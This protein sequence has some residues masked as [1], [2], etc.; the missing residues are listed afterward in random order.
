MKQTI[1]QLMRTKR[2]CL[3]IAM[4]SA[5][6]AL[7]SYAQQW[8]RTQQG[9]RVDLNKT[10]VNICY[11]NNATVRV[12]KTP[13]GKTLTRK[14]LVVTE[15]PQTVK[16]KIADNNNKV[17]LKSEKVET[18]V[19]LQT[20]EVSFS[21]GTKLLFTEKGEAQFTPFNDAGNSTYAVQQNF[22]LDSDEPIY[23]FGQPQNE[24]LSQRHVNR[25]LQPQNVED[26]I[27][28]FTSLKGYGIYWDNY[29]ATT[30]NDD[31]KGTWFRS[32]VAAGIDYY[33]L[34][35]G[36]MDGVMAQ[37][38]Q[39]SG[40]VP[41]FPL[42]TYGFWQS[43]ERYKSSKELE[44]VVARYRQLQIPLDG[45]IQDWQYW[46]NNYLW[47]AM[48]FLNP[49][50]A[51]GKQMIDSVHRSNCHIIFSIWSSFGPETLPYRELASKKMLFNFTTWPESGLS[52]WPPRKDY[53]SGVR[54]YDAFNAEARDIYWKHLT[55]LYNYGTDG[56]WM[57][58]TEPDMIDMKD[59]DFDAPTALGSLR[60]VRCAYPL[61]TVGGVY[62]HQ[63]QTTS[64][65]RVFILTRSGF[66]G[67]QRYGCNV[68]SGDIISTWE[69]MR[70]QLTAGL[71]F[72]LTGNP[73][74][75]CDL[76]GFFAG[77]YNKSWNDNSACQNPAYR[78]LYT[79]W[80]ECGVFY[81]MMRSHGTEVYREFYYYGKPGEPVYDAL[82]GAVKT[83]YSLL[84]Y[85]YSTA[86]QVTH[87]R[88]SFMRA[89]PMA[90]PKDKQVW[91]INEEFLLGQS[92]LAAPVVHAQYTPEVAKQVKAEDGWNQNS[93]SAQVTG[94]NDID[95]SQ[96]KSTKIY[97]P[98]GT[99]WY[100]YWTGE[101]YEGGQEIT[102][103]T[104]IATIPMYVK[105]GSILPIG[106]DVQ[107]ATQKPWD[108]LTLRVYPGADG[109]FILYEDEGDNYNYEKGAYTEIPMTWDEAHRT[110]TIGKRRGQFKGM[111]A[112]RK[113]QVVTPDGKKK[114]VN[115]QG[116]AVRV[117]L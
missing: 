9:I 30:F 40:D 86:W 50:F 114:T 28:F 62:D 33:F 115:Y 99:L 21:N 109:H 31:D 8:S 104:T 75:N 17:T 84:P 66:A 80:I 117:K 110:L 26:G 76:G 92:L 67:Q 56:Y 70:K 88:Q 51:D 45:I 100:D 69:S 71:N 85:L 41:M 105:A 72:T 23:G 4:L 15:Q 16:L 52:S 68:W 55:R 96:Q 81:P 3:S 63:R 18:N 112:K 22:V 54:V 65:K 53:P 5:M 102:K 12:T 42:W 78:E 108:N 37:M 94:L 98:K 57:D 14:S 87:N 38:R 74:F 25:F 20:G 82:V 7:P 107:W 29:S 64:D 116:K 106:P 24:N 90:F 36:D 48:D 46:G 34:Y 73:N 43:R 39:L 2:L 49:D 83:R 1:F 32:E 89:L 59:A 27:P 101:R 93:G 11:M 13:K 58:S 10:T 47:N 19:N 91:N 35:G 6:A 77:A 60:S 111:I 113:F 103:P 79:R 97:L 61:V 44:E 95:F